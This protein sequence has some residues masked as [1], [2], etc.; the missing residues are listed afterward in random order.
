MKKGIYFALILAL[1]SG[2]SIFLSSFVV[3]KIPNAFFFTTAKNVIVAFFIA[4][5]LILFKKFKEIQ[6]LSKKDW[7]IL[8]AVGLIGGSIPFLLFFKGLSISAFSAVNGAFIHKTLFIWVAFLALIFLKEKFSIFQYFALLVILAGIYLIGGFKSLDFGRGE[9][10]IFLATLMWAFES[11]IVKKVLPRINFYVLAFGRMFFGGIIMVSYLLLTNNYQAVFSLTFTQ[12]N[13]IIA[14]S[15][16]LLGYVICYYGALNFT[17][18]TIV[19]SILTL[20][21]PITVI[22]QGLYTGIYSRG[23]VYGAL[24]IICG[25]VLFLLLPKLV[26]KIKKQNLV[27][28][29]RN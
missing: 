14:T 8:L 17:K 5:L 9:V 3:K 24:V 26:N 2:V 23:Q 29:G 19:T 12:I 22:L 13:W 28:Y 20:G 21:F 4:A 27:F 10:L 15:I 7:L 25:V 6:K 16:L 1:I 18:A 11:V